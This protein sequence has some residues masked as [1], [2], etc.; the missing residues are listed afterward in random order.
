MKEKETFVGQLE[1]LSGKNTLNTGMPSYATARQVIIYNDIIDNSKAKYLIVQYCDNDYLENKTLYNNYGS[2]PITGQSEYEYLVKDAAKALKYYPFK[3]TQFLS[4]YILKPNVSGVSFA[5]DDILKYHFEHAY[6][7]LEAL[8]KLEHTNTDVQLIIFDII[9][10]NSAFYMS[11]YVHN[12]ILPFQSKLFTSIIKKLIKEGDYPYFIKQSIILD[13]SKFIG[14]NKRDYFIFD[15]HIRPSTHKRIANILNNTIQDGKSDFE[16]EDLAE[17]KN[18]SS[19]KY[20]KQLFLQKSLINPG[21]SKKWQACDLSSQIG[22]VNSECVRTAIKK[23]DIPGSLNSGPYIDLNPG[24]YGFKI[25]YTGQASI[26]SAIGNWY[27][28]AYPNNHPVKVIDYGEMMGTVGIIK[29][30]ENIFT[31]NEKMKVDISIVFKGNADMSLFDIEITNISNNLQS[32][33]GVIDYPITVDFKSDKLLFFSWSAAEKTHRW[34]AAKSTDIFFIIEDSNKF[35]GEIKLTVMSLGKQ[36]VTISLNQNKLLTTTVNSM[37]EQITLKFNPDLL[38][39]NAKNI[40]HFDLPDAKKPGN[41]D[42][43]TLGFG[44]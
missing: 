15:G 12:E 6:L 4:N 41:G 44:T 26:T 39:D 35:Q 9:F 29:I 30:I 27:V 42:T 10:H 24:V 5:K 20:L 11:N 28:Y 38:K 17:L 16:A 43:R 33:I 34:S 31:L 8:N 3:Y 23:K 25:R 21:N 32:V 13:S 1:K 14:R 2:L 7:F 37:D 36:R 18:V 40:L 22:T 19:K